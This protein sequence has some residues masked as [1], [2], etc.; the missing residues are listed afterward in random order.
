MI[1]FL[2]SPHLYKM[3]CILLKFI[4]KLT[5]KNIKNQISQNL[6]PHMRITRLSSHSYK[7]E[8]SNSVKKESPVS[9]NDIYH[10]TKE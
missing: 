10:N 1:T 3:N 4:A 5:I 9:G 7:S 2:E 6:C 8:E